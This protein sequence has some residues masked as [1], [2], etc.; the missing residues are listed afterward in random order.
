MASGPARKPRIGGLS[1]CSRPERA[2]GENFSGLFERAWI[3]V[4][5]ARI[6]CLTLARTAISRIVP[7]SALIMIWPRMFIISGVM[8]PGRSIG[9]PAPAQNAA[10]SASRS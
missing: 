9:T 2:S 7:P 6:S 8:P 1:N 5:C 10:Q 4:M 3:T